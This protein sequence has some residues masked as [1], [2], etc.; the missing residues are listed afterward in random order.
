MSGTAI[1]HD[2]LVQMGGAERVMAALVRAFPGADLYTT[3]SAPWKLTPELQALRVRTTWMRH[4][5]RPD[6]WYRH[7][8]LLYPLAVE[9]ADLR[10][11][12]VIVSSCWGYSKGVRKRPDAVHICYCHTPTR[13]VWRHDDYVAQEPLGPIRRRLLRWL[14]EPVRSW[15]LHAA[16]R[17]D[18]FIANSSVVAERIRRFY[19]RDAVVIPPPIEAR[20]FRVADTVEDYYLII[21]RLVAYKRLDL[22]IDA[23]NRL[24]R[25]LVI[26][27]DGPDRERLRRLAGPTVEFRGRV[28]DA[29]VTEAA[30]R[31]R[32]LLFPGE[33][34]FGLTPLEANASGRPVV[35]WK[36]GGALETVTDETGVFFDEPTGRSM[37]AAIQELERRDWNPRVLRRH[38]EAYDEP[39]FISR[40]RGF[41]RQVAPAHGAPGAAAHV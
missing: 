33:E 36:G 34:D 6:R 10:R 4:L 20:R 38:A 35:A 26:I 12:D 39:V 29:D 17:P 1:F 5:P 24:R 32:A 31:C 3:L 37:A 15:D 25:R 40:I 18:F 7:Y 27:G 22:A 23:C 41:L 11:Y 16:R 21:S 2:N 19:R 14:I 8:F 30:S 28:P 13:W 9:T